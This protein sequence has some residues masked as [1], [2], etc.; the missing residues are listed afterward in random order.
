MPGGSVGANNVGSAGQPQ[1]GVPGM[2]GAGG[3]FQGTGRPPFFGFPMMGN[4]NASGAPMNPDM[5][6][7]PGAQNPMPNPMTGNTTVNPANPMQGPMN[8]GGNGGQYGM[9]SALMGMG[10]GANLAN[11][12]PVMNILSM[13]LNK[14]MQG[15]G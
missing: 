1:R 13:A 5:P 4:P 8:G 10:G 3:G 11:M 6:G 12:N 2:P 9:L 14:K 15:G 7:V